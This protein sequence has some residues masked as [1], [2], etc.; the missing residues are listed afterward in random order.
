[1]TALLWKAS[2]SATSRIHRANKTYKAHS[3][4]SLRNYFVREVSGS[5]VVVKA[6]S[7]EDISDNNNRSRWF[8]GKRS[9]RKRSEVWN[10]IKSRYLLG[11]TPQVNF[12]VFRVVSWFSFYIS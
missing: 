1:M 10:P 5:F 11:A 2:G 4:R 8:G 3:L 6:A 9:R 12:Y 7:P